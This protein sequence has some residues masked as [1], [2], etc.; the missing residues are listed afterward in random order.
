MQSIQVEKTGT[1]VGHRDCIYAISEGLS[2]EKLYSA[3]ADG[4]VVAWNFDTPD[5]GE[6]LVKLPNSVYALAFDKGLQRLWVGQNFQGIHAIDCISR[7]EIQSAAITTS[8]IFKIVFHNDKLYC[9]CGDGTVVVLDANDLTSIARWRFSEKSARALVISP[10]GEQLAIGY[11]D[12]MIRIMSIRQGVVLHEIAAHENS[13]FALA[14]SPNGQYL[15]SGS[16]DARIK[17]WNVKAGY[18]LQQSIA[19]HLYAINDIA[20][21]PEGRYFVT[22]SMDKSIKV[23]DAETFSLLKVIDK[24]RHA[25]HGTSVNKVLWTE[26]N[27]Y[28]VSGSDDRTL[29]V[30]NLKIS[31]D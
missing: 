22:C 6:L 12:H 29:S 15:L 20:F 7:Q 14:Y 30:W 24:S 26:Y 5:Q 17:I 1:Y 13:V 8:T 4:M 16:R 25:G 27:G 19:A 18:A 21:S 31:K 3:G 9:A 11:S 10:D 28:I 2:K 23:W